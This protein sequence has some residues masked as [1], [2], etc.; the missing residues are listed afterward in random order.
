MEDL[1]ETSAELDPPKYVY[2]LSMEDITSEDNDSNRHCK[3]SGS[4]KE[5]DSADEF[6]DEKGIAY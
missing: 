3:D 4:E 2:V 1:L 5:S 6:K